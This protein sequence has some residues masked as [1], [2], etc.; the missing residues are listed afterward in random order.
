[1]VRVKRRYFLFELIPSDERLLKSCKPLD[2]EE[3]AIVRSLREKITELF[4]DFGMASVVQ[5]MRLKRFNGVTRTGVIS[6]KRGAHLMV[7]S[8]L[9]FIRKIDDCD[10]S[11]RLIHLS[12]TFRGSLKQLKKWHTKQISLWKKQL[13]DSSG[14]DSR[15]KT[16]IENASKMEMSLIEESKMIVVEKDDDKDLKIEDKSLLKSMI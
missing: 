1:M 7:M 9:P 15:V 12:G 5:H 16:L 8:S 4:G 6:C 14:S 2:I 3:K 11:V 10:C 13:K